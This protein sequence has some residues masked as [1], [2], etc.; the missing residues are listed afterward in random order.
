MFQVSDVSSVNVTLSASQAKILVFIDGGVDAPQFL[1]DGIIAEASAFILNPAQ[2]GIKQI[3]EILQNHPQVE[4]IHLVSHGSPGSIQLGNT[5]LSLDTI[6]EYQKDLKYWY[7]KSLL[8][9]GCNVAAGD[10]GAE[11]LS[12]L[13]QLT[14]ANIA[15]S[16]TK[17]GNTSLGGD[18]NLEVTTNSHQAK[19][20]FE[21]STLEQYLFTL[22]IKR[23]SVDDS[24]NQGNNRS[25][26]SSISEDGRYVTFLSDASNLVPGDTN[27]TSDIFV[28]DRELNITERVSVNSIGTQANNRSHTSSISGDARYV[29]FS[30]YADNL[31]AG[32]TNNT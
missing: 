22:A 9:Y 14:G 5:C 7:A 12:K 21:Q 23:V 11:L 29:T 25:F 1:A 28:Y 17:T 6:A 30:S 13:H 31:V 15:G 2:D 16:K 8:I 18:W 32:D 4:S 27:N 26:Y 20:A 19:L 3:T 24:G 10:A